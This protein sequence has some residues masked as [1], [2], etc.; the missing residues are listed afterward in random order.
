MQ[1]GCEAAGWRGQPLPGSLGPAVCLLPPTNPVWLVAD[2]NGILACMVTVFPG[3]FAFSQPMKLICDR[4]EK[5]PRHRRFTEIYRTNEWNSEETRSG[6]GSEWESTEHVRRI[7]DVALV[8]TRAATLIDAGC[9]EA[10]WVCGI[11]PRL[12]HVHGIDIVGEPALRNR[13]QNNMQGRADSLTFHTA[14]I[15][16]D[17][18]PAG[19]MILCRDVL[20]HLSNA[21]CM[22]ALANFCRS[23]S[24][25]LLATSFE[26]SCN[27]D[28]ETGLWRKQDLE[29]A[30]FNLPA[31]VKR[32]NEKSPLD[33]GRHTGKFLNLWCLQSLQLD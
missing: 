19:D 10:N 7:L 16:T 20:V 31:P 26:L 14:D 18:L 4:M 3:K 33:G 5:R 27:H 6:R 25:Y 23:G 28:I 2:D 15:V 17:L 11:R 9:G 13:W 21:D 12:K 22:A 32:W 8:F 24:R 30:P 1:A 29:K